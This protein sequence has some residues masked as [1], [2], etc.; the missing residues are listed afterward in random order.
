[1]AYISDQFRE[2]RMSGLECP[3]Q[4]DISTDVKPMHSEARSTKYSG[5][6]S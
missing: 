5:L 6:F 1:V 3:A 4:S 2:L